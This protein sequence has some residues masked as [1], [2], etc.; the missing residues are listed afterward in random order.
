MKNDPK[1]KLF[2][3]FVA[4]LSSFTVW[5]SIITGFDPDKSDPITK[6]AFFASLMLFLTGL[7][8]MIYIYVSMAMNNKNIF[9]SIMAKSILHAS[10]FSI[11]IT[12]TL[13]LKTI[14]VLGILE[15]GILLF[16]FILLELY[17]KAKTGVQN[18]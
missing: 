4:T 7:F 10:L 13:A 9:Y 6:I 17:L 5:L 2:T 18:E 3:L 11:F 8:S 15:F 14:K 1:Y 12:I 16:L